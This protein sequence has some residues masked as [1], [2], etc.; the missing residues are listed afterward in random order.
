M[1]KLLLLAILPLLASCATSLRESSATSLRTQGYQAHIEPSYGLRML[2]VALTPGAE[3]Q[4]KIAAAKSSP[5]TP[6]GKN[7]EVASM[8]DL[9]HPG[10]LIGSA[11]AGVLAQKQ[12]TQRPGSTN[13][14]QVSNVEW[15]YV[16]V[17][18]AGRAVS[19]E[20][21]IALKDAANNTLASYSCGYQ[22]LIDF[23]GNTIEEAFA[24]NGALL[25]KILAKGASFCAERFAEKL[26]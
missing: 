12:I 4:Q 20:A 3:M 14:L 9:P 15:V 19:M 23:G 5:Y 6:T 18:F 22:S 2:G 21:D 11:V 1:K 17:P 7:S 13:T 25:K 24:N 10:T 16:P 8:F 26:D